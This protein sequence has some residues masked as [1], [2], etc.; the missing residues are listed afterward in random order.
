MLLSWNLFKLLTHKIELLLE[1]VNLA[2]LPIDQRLL[3]LYINLICICLLLIH[4]HCQVINLTFRRRLQWHL[5]WRRHEAS[6][7]RY[8]PCLRRGHHQVR[9]W[10]RIVNHLLRWIKIAAHYR[11]LLLRKVTSCTATP[12]KFEISSSQKTFLDWTQVFCLQQFL[13]RRRSISLLKCLLDQ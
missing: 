1:Q 13:V 9:H 4:R 8:P 12:I 2:L 6:M 11:C 3:C 10:H 7:V 5:S